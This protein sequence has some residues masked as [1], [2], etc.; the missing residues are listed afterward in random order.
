[1][2]TDLW[3]SPQSSVLPGYHQG[4]PSTLNTLKKKIICFVNFFL[5]FQN[6]LFSQAKPNVLLIFPD[7]VPPAAIHSGNE[8]A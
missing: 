6:S 7:C 8:G 4:H 5:V 1:M 2:D 3:S